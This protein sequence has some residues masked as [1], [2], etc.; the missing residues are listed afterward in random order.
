MRYAVQIEN[1]LL[2]LGSDAVILVEKV[3]ERALWLLERCIGTRLQVSQIRED[4]FLEFL[5]VLDGSTEC[6]K[7]EGKAADNVGARDVKKVIP[8][9]QSS[10]RALEAHR[11]DSMIP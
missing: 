1:L 10:A 3:Q 6:L 4:A 7:A 2:L 11:H 9:T 5:R 8:T